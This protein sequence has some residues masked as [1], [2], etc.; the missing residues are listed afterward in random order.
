MP[1]AWQIRAARPDDYDAIVRVVDKW[2]GRPVATAI[3]RLF[4][5]HFF[6]TSAVAESNGQLVGFLVGFMSPSSPTDAYIHFVGVHPT[7]RGKGLARELYERFFD[8]ARAD[9]RTSVHA[10]TAARNRQSIAFHRRMGFD[11]SAPLDNYNGQSTAGAH[12]AFS[13]AL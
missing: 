8:A 1:G 13:R 5:D 11:V 3:P 4:L 2:W 10:I 6:T 12:V 9:G 7:L